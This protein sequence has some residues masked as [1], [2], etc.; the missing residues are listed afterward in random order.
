MDRHLADLI[1][2][3][4]LICG[5]VIVAIVALALNYMKQMER[6]KRQPGSSDSRVMEAVEALRKEVADL[7]DTSTRYDVSFDTALQRMESR[8]GAVENRTNRQEQEQTVI[9]GRG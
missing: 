7:R 9:A 1:I 2:N 6:L 5:G 8:I 4:T 3:G